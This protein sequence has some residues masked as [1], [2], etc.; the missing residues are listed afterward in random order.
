MK[1]K[2]INTQFHNSYNYHLKGPL[3]KNNDNHQNI[4]KNKKMKIIK[5]SKIIN[6]LKKLINS[7][8]LSFSRNLMK[9]MSDFWQINEVLSLVFDEELDSTD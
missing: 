1:K 2:S 7:E 6:I 9:E 5:N 3:S 4:I 8:N